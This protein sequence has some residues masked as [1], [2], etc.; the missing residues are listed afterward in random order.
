MFNG[1]LVTEILLLNALFSFANS[2][3]SVIY[4]SIY[5]GHD[6]VPPGLN[7]IKMS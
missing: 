4:I 1:S 3:Y 6:L 7:L 5:K 2:L